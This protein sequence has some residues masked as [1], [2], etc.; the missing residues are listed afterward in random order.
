MSDRSA[1]LLAAVLPSTVALFFDGSAHGAPYRLTADAFVQVADPFGAMILQGRTRDASGLGIEVLAFGDVGGSPSPEGDVLV[2]ALSYRDAKGRGEARLGRLVL[3]T[4]ALL[5]VQMDGLV[6]LGR[7]PLGATLELFGGV[8]VS[9]RF[10]AR[11]FDWVAG[12]RLSESVSFGTIGLAYMQRREQAQVVDHELGLDLALFLGD[13]MELASRVA[14][15]LSTPGISEAR[16]AS[17]FEYHAV[18]LELSASQHVP[19][20]VLPATS[21]FSVLGNVAHRA[22][23]ADVRVYATPRLDLRATGGLRLIDAHPYEDA[24]LLSVLRI[25]EG[26][27]FGS[28]GLELRRQ[29]ASDGGWTGARVFSR[30]PI[31]EVVS[32]SVEA[33]VVRPDESKRGALL[34]FGL[35]ALTWRI[36]EYFE[37]AVASEVTESRETRTLDGLLRLTSVLE[38][39]EGKP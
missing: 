6:L 13:R 15:D 4:G 33:E 37:L 34:G 16:M 26:G 19:S 20:R 5:P 25:G 14:Y 17:A 32:A 11:A 27:G 29:G 12:G 7:T 23:V 3:G 36:H 2:A 24:A 30:V 22:L 31:L 9:P 28:V 21:L 35:L 8:P 39:E 18:R 10:S 38:P 1:R